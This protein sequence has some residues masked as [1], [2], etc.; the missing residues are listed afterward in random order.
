MN[1][2]ITDY[3][4]YTPEQA[5]I[6]LETAFSKKDIVNAVA[7][8]DFKAEAKIVLQRTNVEINEETVDLTAKLLELS[9]VEYILENGFPDYSKVKRQFSELSKTDDDMYYI[10]ET[11]IYENGQTYSNIVFM[12]VENKKWRVAMHEEK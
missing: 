6:S 7:S 9:L 12:T 2:F 3:N 11:L 8:K 1:N 10:E 5:I 4:Y